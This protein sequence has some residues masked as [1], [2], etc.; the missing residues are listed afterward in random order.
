MANPKS[1]PGT[2][3]DLSREAPGKSSWPGGRRG[4]PPRHPARP[5]AGWMCWWGALAEPTASLKVDSCSVVH[6]DVED[7]VGGTCGRH[8]LYSLRHFSVDIHSLDPPRAGGERHHSVWSAGHAVR[9]PAEASDVPG[10]DD[11]GPAAARC[12]G[13][14]VGGLGGGAATISTKSP[15]PRATWHARDAGFRARAGCPPKSAGARGLMD[16]HPLHARTRPR[17]IRRI[18]ER[19]ENRRE[20]EKDESPTTRPLM[21]QQRLS[22]NVQRKSRL[23]GLL[24][25]AD[26]GAIWFAS[27]KGAS[28][29]WSPVVQTA[30]PLD[31]MS[32]SIFLNPSSLRSISGSR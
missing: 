10:G 31:G 11:D 20:V 7:G 4:G 3:P 19:E 12:G 25:G 5:S 16:A 14:K 17:G 9:H 29:D 24:S 28:G 32:W 1:A 22:S 23:L 26:L 8:P 30:A 6:L 13:G 18:Y 21:L 15:A 27:T 2:P